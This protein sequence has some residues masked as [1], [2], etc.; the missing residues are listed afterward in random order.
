MINE[1]SST[2]GVGATYNEVYNSLAASNGANSIM[3]DFMMALDTISEGYFKA[4]YIPDDEKATITNAPDLLN[5]FLELLANNCSD[6]VA[7][8]NFYGKLVC[9]KFFE[10]GS[11]DLG[12]CAAETNSS[13]LYNCL[14]PDSRNC[15]FHLDSEYSDVVMD[16]ESPADC[17]G[18]V[19]DTTGSMGSEIEEVKNVIKSFIQAEENRHTLCYTLVPFNDYSYR[20]PYEVNSE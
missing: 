1:L 14:D 11:P 19:V 20:T 5:T 8:R 18:F 9:L 12:A 3:E 4:C 17:L 15:I 16:S 6:P 7:I 13:G 2:L 10:S